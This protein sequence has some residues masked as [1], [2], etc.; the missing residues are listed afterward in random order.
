LIAGSDITHTTASVEIYDPSTGNFDT[1]GKPATLSG[2]SF[3][4]LLN[5]GRVLLSGSVGTFPPIVPGA[6]VY[7]PS[8]GTFSPVA[9]WPGADFWSPVVLPGE[10]VLLASGDS[11]SELYNPTAGT[12]GLTGSLPY[13]N[14]VPPEASLLNGKV[15]FSG[16]GGA[17]SRAELYDP[18]MG[19]FAAT[20]SLSTARTSHSATLLT[21]GTVLVAGGAGQSVGSQ[22]ALASAEI[23]DPATSTFAVTGSLHSAR[24][25]HRAT[26]LNSG[27]VLVT[28]GS[29]TDGG[30]GSTFI[31]AIAGAELYTPPV[32]V[33]APSLFSLSGDRQG[34]GAIWHSKTGQIASAGSP[35]VAGEALSMYT[36]SL[37]DGGAIPPQVVIGGRLAEVLYFGFCS[38]PGYN[39]VNFRVPNGV[40]PGAA[41]S[42][43]L[44]YLSR[45]SNA[46]TIGV[47]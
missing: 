21:D 41:I 26:L 28:G 15:L 24:Y 46:V 35:A 17:D 20:A 42:V 8:A 3:V 18:A 31:S 10:A 9:N 27:Q 13:F 5:D 32:V 12:F 47:Q 45:S 33:P 25:F 4:T 23:Y 36:T 38:Y 30:S 34:Q 37:A 6:E 29:A 7:D 22:P 44:T 43:R 40:A 16:G 39:Q 19:I 11:D 14:G 2:V 1:A